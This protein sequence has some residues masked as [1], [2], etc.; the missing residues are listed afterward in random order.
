M[1]D[2]QK[3][4]SQGTEQHAEQWR[5]MSYLDKGPRPSLGTTPHSLLEWGGKG[6]WREA[7][8]SALDGNLPW[9]AKSS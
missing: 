9:L 1:A 3:H 5:K 8:M 2:L 7:R 4:Y 6:R